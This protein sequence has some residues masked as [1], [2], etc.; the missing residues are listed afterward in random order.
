MA[1]PAGPADITPEWLTGLLSSAGHLTT[2]R[3]VGCRVEPM[4]DVPSFTGSLQR[5]L[6]TYDRQPPG[7]P[8]TMV[9]KSSIDQPELR[10]LIQSMGFYQR[11]VTFYR[12]LAPKTPVP[13]PHCYFGRVDADGRSLLL[14]EDLTGCRP[15]R[16]TDAM[17]SDDA[18]GA[19]DAIARVHAR[20]WMS[21]D[22]RDEPPFD[23]DSIM[24]TDRAAARFLDCW[25]LFLAKLSAPVSDATLRL[26]EIIATGLGST[27]RELFHS[28]PLTLIHHDFQGDNLIF[29]VDGPGSVRVIDWQLT[30]RGRG[31]I[32]LAY[33]LSGSLE[34]GQR[35]RSE[36]R[37]V[38]RYV[39]Q[40]A[41]HG[42]TY[43]AD[44]A[45]QEYRRALLIPPSRLAIAVA[46][47]PQ[48]TAHP[49]APWEVLFDRQL[50]AWFDNAESS[51]T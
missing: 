49:G 23:P 3:V 11:E 4:A 29:D 43:P 18:Q 51:L 24:P 47:S 7:A 15:G 1:E 44:V 28:S 9:A 50:R 16:S 19:V 35:S 30:A 20:W 32:D 34:P 39:N 6:L 14:L 25:P 40:L 13:V 22:F 33:L 2:G 36:A 42:I 31:I 38:A 46:S 12:E 26:G 48:L 45:G 27:L 10:A 17:T 41:R 21:P 37:M 5:I 8:A